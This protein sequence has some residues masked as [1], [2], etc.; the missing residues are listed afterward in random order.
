ML[1]AEAGW[2]PRPRGSTTRLG[3]AGFRDA[4]VY[5]IGRPKDARGGMA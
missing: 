3:H 4:L 1:L 5:E 2:S